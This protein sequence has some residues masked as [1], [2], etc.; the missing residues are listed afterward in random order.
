[1]PKITFIEHQGTVHELVAEYGDSLMDLAVLNAVPG[2]DG[3]CG[4]FCSC[5]T[6]HVLVDPAWLTRTGTATAEEIAMLASR[7]ERKKNSRLACQIKAS[8]VL[9]GLVVRIPQVQR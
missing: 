3:N 6:C 8:A 2:I 1:M 5:A 7:R 9:D 4:G